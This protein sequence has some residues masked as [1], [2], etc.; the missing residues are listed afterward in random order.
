MNWREWIRVEGAPHSRLFYGAMVLFCTLGVAFFTYVAVGNPTGSSLVW[1]VA[2]GARA[3][4]YLLGMLQAVERLL[5]PERAQRRA[6]ELSEGIRLGILIG[7]W[8]TMVLSVMG[9]ALALV[10]SFYVG[11]DWQDVCGDLKLLTLSMLLLCFCLADLV[12]ETTFSQAM[13][14]TAWQQGAK[15]G[16]GG[17][18][19]KR[20]S[21]RSLY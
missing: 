7:R 1:R 16:I 17:L 15:D 11:P 2:Y 14:T 13:W 6:A 4:L 18:A 9:F 12:G 19:K 20:I 10:A 5:R 8:A 3:P 21:W